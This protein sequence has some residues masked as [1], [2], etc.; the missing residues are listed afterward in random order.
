[1]SV[2]SDCVLDIIARKLFCGEKKMEND[3]KWLSVLLEEGR[4]GGVGGCLWRTAKKRVFSFFFFSFFCLQSVS[5]FLAILPIFNAQQ[6][7]QNV[8]NF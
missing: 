8:F 7:R 5:K 3:C 2:C 1:V 4:K 6:Y